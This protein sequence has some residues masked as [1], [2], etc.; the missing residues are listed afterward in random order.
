MSFE[1]KFVNYPIAICELH[2][3]L[4]STECTNKQITDVL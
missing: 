1:V 3:K 4:K 2:M